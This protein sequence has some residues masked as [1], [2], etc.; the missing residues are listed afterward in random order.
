M[1]DAFAH[2]FFSWAGDGL[3]SDGGIDQVRSSQD[4]R[5]APGRRQGRSTPRQGRDGGRERLAFGHVEASA[6][7][8]GTQER[9][10]RAS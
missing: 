9:R 2:S 6:E 1:Q 3:I 7:S 4:L 5:A 10:P 8:E